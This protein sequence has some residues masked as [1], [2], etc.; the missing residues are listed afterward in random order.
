MDG[1]HDLGGKQGFGPVDV[2][3][4]EAAFHADWEGRMWAIA[5]CA[6]GRDGWTLDW[7]RHCRELIDPVDYLARP[8][9]DSWM[10][11][12]TATYVDSGTISLDEI[13]AAKS[14]VPAVEPPPPKSR[15]EVL[16]DVQAQGISFEKP[17]EQAPRFAVGD[18]IMTRQLTTTH[19]TRLP[20]YARG[21][22]GIIH[23]HHGAHIFAD[24]SAR[25]DESAQHLYSVVFDACDLW[26][27]AENSKDRVFLDL[28]ESYLE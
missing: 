13:I 22:P 16:R 19:H 25:G 6:G 26:F 12:Y 7:W 23:A 8:Y 1:I 4:E 3:E 18:R 20:G 27:E 9:F 5:Q 11:A 28:W 21:K 15:Q 10:Q 2:D 17:I 24:S 14:A